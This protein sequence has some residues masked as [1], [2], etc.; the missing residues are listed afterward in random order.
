MNT[1]VIDLISGIGGDKR[2]L[3][4]DGK[5]RIKLRER[6]LD[7]RYPF[8]DVVSADGV[9]LGHADSYVYGGVAFAVHTVPFA[10]HVSFEECEFITR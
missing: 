4:A 5:V 2:H 9:I 10:G 3:T 1:N 7:E 8:G 6:G